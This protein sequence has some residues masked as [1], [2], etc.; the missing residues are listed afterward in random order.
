MLKCRYMH[1]LHTVSDTKYDMALKA[2]MLHKTSWIL[3]R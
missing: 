1:V 3:P 2:F